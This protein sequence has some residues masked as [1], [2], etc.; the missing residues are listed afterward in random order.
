MSPA[1]G[2]WGKWTDF[3]WSRE[4]LGPLKREQPHAPASL[5]SF[6]ATYLEPEVGPMPPTILWSSGA[7][8]SVSADAIRRHPKAFYE[9]LLA[10][11]AH[12]N[13]AVATYYL[14]MTWGYIFGHL[15]PLNECAAT[16]P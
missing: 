13:E 3:N 11:T 6:W 16:L 1:A 10:T 12:E 14:E 5:A 8:F 4:Y 2:A 15:Q 7:I 9:R